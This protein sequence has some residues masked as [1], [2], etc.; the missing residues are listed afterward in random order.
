MRHVTP[1]MLVAGAFMVCFVVLAVLVI[2]ADTQGLGGFHGSIST[3]AHGIASQGL[4]GY[5][6]S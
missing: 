2:S 6:G 1:G 5:H 4:G 3:A